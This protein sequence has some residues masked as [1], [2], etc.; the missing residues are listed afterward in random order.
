MSAG[1]TNSGMTDTLPREGKADSQHCFCPRTSLY[2]GHPLEKV[3]HSED[4][5]PHL[6]CAFQV[7]PGPIRLA[8]KVNNGKLC[9]KK[10]RLRT[11]GFTSFHLCDIDKLGQTGQR[12]SF[13]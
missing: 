5:S 3:T 12:S 4:R 8:I 6:R 10:K 9:G 11:Q 7:P 13:I 1:N 2:W